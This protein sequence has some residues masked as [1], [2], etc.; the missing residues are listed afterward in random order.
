MAVHVARG[1]VVD[2]LVAQEHAQPIVD[3]LVQEDVDQDAQDVE[4]A[5][6]VLVGIHALVAELVLEH[7]LLVVQPHVGQHVKAVVALVVLD[8]TIVKVV[9]LDV[10]HY[11]QDVLLAGGVLVVIKPAQEIV[12]AE[13]PDAIVAQ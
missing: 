10:N 7:V 1:V 12:L 2:V 8:V 5:V 13:L 4:A 11:V 3:R 9:L 6:L